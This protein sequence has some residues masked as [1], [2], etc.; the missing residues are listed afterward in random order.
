MK[1]LADVY[2]R[3]VPIIACSY[4]GA[5]AILRQRHR[6]LKEFQPLREVI[7]YV[8]LAL[9]ASCCVGAAGTWMVVLDHFT[10]RQHLSLIHI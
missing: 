10:S 2:K 9:V 6:T 3:Q 8:V 1:S 4:G 5:A 7:F